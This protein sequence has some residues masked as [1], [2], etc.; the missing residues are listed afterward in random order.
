MLRNKENKAQRIYSG[1]EVIDPVTGHSGHVSDYYS[2]G[3]AWYACIVSSE[4]P[5]VTREV[6][7]VT[8]LDG[9]GKATGFRLELSS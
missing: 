1:A 5:S 3:G 2:A 4:H 8:Q 7:Y 6:Q 9:R